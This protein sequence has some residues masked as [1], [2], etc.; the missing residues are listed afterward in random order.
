VTVRVGTW[1]VE[2]D[3]SPGTVE[4]LLALRAHVLLLT[5]VPPSLVLPGYRTT[6]LRHPTMRPDAP[7][8]QHYAA[9]AALDGLEL[10]QVE[11][12]HGTLAVTSAAARVGGATFVSTVLPWPHAPAPPYVGT[13]QAE[14]TE[15]ALDELEPWLTELARQGPLVWGGDW[16][17]PLAGSLSGFSRRAHDRIALAVK[18]LGL[19]VHTRDAAAQAKP[20]GLHCR[21]V[22]HLASASAGLLDEPVGGSP[23]S[24]HDA[25]VVELHGLQLP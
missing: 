5:E 1:N 23:Y 4:L 7:D 15:R 14:Q 11:P 13:T 20:N 8:G 9:V 16:N 2:G 18:R 10:Q 17:H 25:Y 21:S 22:D 6:K 3:P 24:T 12:P 19:T